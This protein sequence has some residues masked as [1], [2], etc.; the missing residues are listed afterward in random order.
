MT[1]SASYLEQRHRVMQAIT[2]CNTVGQIRYAG[3]MFNLLSLRWQGQYYVPY[4]TSMLS[5]LSERHHNILCQT[6]KPSAGQSITR[7]R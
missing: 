2:S 3:K 5:Y 6:L 4:H 7:G 1:P